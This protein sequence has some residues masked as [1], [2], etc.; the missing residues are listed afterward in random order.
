MSQ[1]KSKEEMEALRDQYRSH[2]YLLPA[3][4][5]PWVFDRDIGPFWLILSA[6]CGGACWETF[7]ASGA[8]Y[9]NYVAV[10]RIVMGSTDEGR[11]MRGWQ[12]LLGPLMLNFAAGRVSS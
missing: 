11:L 3:K 7:K 1:I 10:Q 4:R 8:V 2:G 5:K 6:H 12:I 9:V